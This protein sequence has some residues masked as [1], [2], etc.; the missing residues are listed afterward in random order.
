MMSE[1]DINKKNAPGGPTYTNRPERRPPRCERS[2]TCESNLKGGG[3][4]QPFCGRGG[5]AK[6]VVR[7]RKSS[8]ASRVRKQK[9]VRCSKLSALTISLEHSCASFSSSVLWCWC[10]SLR[11]CFPPSSTC[12]G[13][14]W[15]TFLGGVPRLKR[16]C[17]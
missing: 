16:R 10:C 6:N 9:Q 11:N 3:S 15:S 12:L 5:S 1:L 4:H 8:I 13:A 7:G 17:L 14:V 2:T